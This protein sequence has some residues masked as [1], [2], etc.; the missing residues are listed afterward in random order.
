MKCYTGYDPGDVMTDTA[1]PVN[2]QLSDNW[3]YGAKPPRIAD[4]CRE[5]VL[6]LVRQP[7]DRM[8]CRRAGAASYLCREIRSALPLRRTFL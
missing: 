1:R 6:R 4:S 7:I 3:R 8:V 5:V 2:E